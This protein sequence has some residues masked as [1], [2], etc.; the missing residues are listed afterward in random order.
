LAVSQAEPAEP[1]LGSD[2]L[3]EV[4]GRRFDKPSSR[5]D[6]AAHLRFFSGKV[7]QLH[8]GGGAGARRFGDLASC[9]RRAAPC[10]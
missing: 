3:V 1:V 6:A 5:E 10:D 2:S 9:G 8:S 7:M 4:A